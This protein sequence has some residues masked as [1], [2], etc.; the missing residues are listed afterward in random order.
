[1]IR[2][3]KTTKKR[4][5][6]LGNARGS[7]GEA[8]KAHHKMRRVKKLVQKRWES[9]ASMVISKWRTHFCWSRCCESGNH[10]VFSRKRT[11]TEEK[12]RTRSKSAL[13]A[14]IRPHFEKNGISHVLIGYLVA[15]G[16]SDG[17]FFGHV[18]LLS[19]YMRFFVRFLSRFS[20]RHPSVLAL[21]TNRGGGK[22]R[23]H[24]SKVER[25]DSL[26]GGSDGFFA[27]SLRCVV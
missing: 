10:R 2:S 13:R 12:V 27:R 17:V 21:R 1:M 5:G 15:G 7:G 18:C 9:Q 16:V 3:Q 4:Q 25:C 11:R 20:S 23:A 8:A 14:K 26:K 19:R 22:P 6:W 24:A